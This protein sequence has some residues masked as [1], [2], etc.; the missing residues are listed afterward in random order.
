MVT[1]KEEQ[2][3]IKE[4]NHLTVRGQGSET[5]VFVHGFGTNQGVWDQVIKAFIDD[6]RIISFDH[7]GCGKSNF[8]AFS[9]RRYS[10]L[11]S[12]ANDLVELCQATQL[13]TATFIAHSMGAM[14]SLLASILFP[15]FFER[16]IAIGTT[17]RYLNDEDYEGGFTAKD[18]QEIY[19]HAS[20]DYAA[21]TSGFAPAMIGADKPDL[22]NYLVETL[23]QMRPDIAL[24]ILRVM[25]ESDHR[26]D[27]AQVKTPT[28][29]VQSR[30]DR[31]VP[32]S[33]GHYLN[34]EIAGSHYIELDISG[35]L[36][37]LTAPDLIISNIR[38]ALS[39]E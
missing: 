32:V 34:Q 6:F 8:A 30:S 19:K 20:Q 15:D 29:I 4:R 25:L 23:Q 39:H 18:L 14:A 3:R 22:S 35:H 5:L 13:G 36:P 24:S 9:P 37:H 2:Q 27:L 33:V 17:P 11:Y 38:A 16:I 31:A 26:A 12:Y 28:W 21:W 7:V 1:V 10:S